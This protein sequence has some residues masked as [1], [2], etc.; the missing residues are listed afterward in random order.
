[1]GQEVFIDA[2]PVRD[3]YDQIG[4]YRVAGVPTVVPNDGAWYDLLDFTTRGGFQPR[5]TLVGANVDSGGEAYATFRILVNGNL[6]P[7]R[8]YSE[9]TSSPAVVYDP[10]ARIIKPIDLPQGSH[11]QVQGKI[12]TGASV[13]YGMYCRIRVEYVDF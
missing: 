2:R 11:I 10:G 5:L 7:D 13:G 4:D 6:I 8:L 3:A 12:G 1:M 9:F